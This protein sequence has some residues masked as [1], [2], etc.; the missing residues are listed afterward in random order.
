MRTTQKIQPSNLSE[1]DFHL[2]LWK[3][4]QIDYAGPF[5]GS[6]WLIWIDAYSKYGNAEQVSSANG[7]NTVRKFR[8]I[9]DM[10]GDREQ[11]VSDN[12]TPFT[13]R[14]YGEFCNQHGIRHIWSAPYHPATIGEAERLVQVFKRAIRTNSDPTSYSTSPT[15]ARKFDT[16]FEV[17]RFVQRYCTVPHS[18]TKRTPSKLLF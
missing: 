8:E 7:F 6:M 12:D 18:I 15:S 17:R 13:S 4:L 5:Y 3:R 1:Y 9:F 16:E 11:I 14:E 2:G 10:L